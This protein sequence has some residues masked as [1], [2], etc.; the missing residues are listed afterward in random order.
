MKTEHLAPLHLFPVSYDFANPERKYCSLLAY[1]RYDVAAEAVRV[2]N[3]EEGMCVMKECGVCRRKPVVGNRITRLECGHG[4]HYHCIV[5]CLEK[6]N[7]CPKCCQPAYDII[8]HGCY[9][10]ASDV[11][12]HSDSDSDSDD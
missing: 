12:S 4:F 8:D 11:D 6:K 7:A 2:D 5:K 10:P 9:D 3:A 1:L